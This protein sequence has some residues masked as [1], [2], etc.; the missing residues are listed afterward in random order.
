MTTVLVEASVPTPE[1]ERAARMETLKRLWS[2]PDISPLV[3]FDDLFLIEEAIHGD[4]V[5]RIS[6]R[7]LADSLETLVREYP[8]LNN[9]VGDETLIARF[10]KIAK[11]EVH[12][13]S[14]N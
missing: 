12:F 7:E 2:A 13:P 10:V 8:F 6:P 1:E 4:L 14:P 5:R 3:P 11:G 9:P